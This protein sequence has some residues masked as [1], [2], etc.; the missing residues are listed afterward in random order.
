MIIARW[1]SFLGLQQDY[2]S[3]SLLEGSGLVAWHNGSHR[4]FVSSVLVSIQI[5]WPLGRFARATS[6]IDSRTLP[7]V[8]SFI[9]RRVRACK[10]R[11]MESF[12]QKY[13]AWKVILVTF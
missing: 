1:Y 3:A 5:L 10:F 12:T 9:S 11:H 2:I 7:G 13:P 8:I 4:L 6:S